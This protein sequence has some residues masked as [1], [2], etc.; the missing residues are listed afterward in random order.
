MIG[1]VQV[2]PHHRP[3]LVWHARR[4]A[5]HDEEASATDLARSRVELYLGRA[6]VDHRRGPDCEHLCDV[7][8][9]E[10]PSTATEKK[11]VG[12]GGAG[13]ADRT[14]GGVGVEHLLPQHGLVLAHPHVQ[15]HV[16]CLGPPTEWRQPTRPSVAPS[17]SRDKN[18]RRIGKSQSHRQVAG[19]NGRR[20]IT[21][22][23]LAIAAASES[24]V[25]RPAAWAR[26]ALPSLPP[27]LPFG[28]VSAA[29]PMETKRDLSQSSS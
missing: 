14:H 1:G 28:G 10:R 21:A 22:A 24:T 26:R 9:D 6:G 17:R 20:T 16:A 12:W 7:S 3:R 5:P 13:R 11:G 25:R 29:R 19:R 8:D 2:F 27:P 4:I 15:R 23:P 18:T